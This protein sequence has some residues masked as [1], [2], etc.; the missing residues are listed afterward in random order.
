MI[1]EFGI[2]AEAQTK[3]VIYIGVA[4]GGA[5]GAVAPPSRMLRKKI[6]AAG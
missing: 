6:E 4:R 1:N 3:K 5:G 2:C